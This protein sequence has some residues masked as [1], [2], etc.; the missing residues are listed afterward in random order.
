MNERERANKALEARA[1]RLHERLKNQANPLNDKQ[2]KPKDDSP[3]PR[4]N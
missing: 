4:K 1:A 3:T 2:P